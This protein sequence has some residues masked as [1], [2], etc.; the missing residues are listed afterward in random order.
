MLFEIKV[1]RV[2][3]LTEFNL[4]LNDVNTLIDITLDTS[5]SEVYQRKNKKLSQA[6]VETL[7]FS[8]PGSYC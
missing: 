7:L 1:K 3:L 8:C 2:G 6:F 5:I 4:A